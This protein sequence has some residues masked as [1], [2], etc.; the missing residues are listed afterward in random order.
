MYVS[1][2]GGIIER[3]KYMSN[4][5]I[6]D[7]LDSAYHWDIDCYYLEGNEIDDDVDKIME[8]IKG[9]NNGTS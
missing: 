3:N 4:E 2:N 8:M 6:R 9:V 7:I 1:L 5:K